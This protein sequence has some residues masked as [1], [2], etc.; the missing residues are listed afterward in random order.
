MFKKI[1]KAILID[2]FLLFILSLTPLLW[3]RG[4]SIMVG[5]DNVFPLNPIEFIKGRF[6]TWSN[7]GL[8]Q[9]Q[10]LIMGTIPIHLIDSLSYIFGFS[11]QTTQKIVY[12]FWFFLMGFS[13]YILASIINRKS[14]VFKLTAVVLYQF[15]FF[16][17]QGWWVGERTKFSAL[18]ALPL[19]LSVLILVYQQKIKP[20]RAVIY[21][22]LIL[23]LF[24]AGGLYGI[25]LF[26]GFF[27]AVGVFIFYF[28]F[29]SLRQR[30]YLI[31]KNLLLTSLITILGFFLINAYFLFPA[32]NSLISKYPKGVSQVGGLSGLIEWSK[33]ISV[34][35]SFLNLFRLQGMAEWYGNPE[36]PYAQTFLNNPYFIALSFLWP[37]L[38][39]SSLIFVRQEKKRVFI[40]YFFLVYLVGIFFTA[41]THPPLGFIYSFL[42]KFI[43]GFAIFRSP[44]YKFAP[45]LFLANA[46]LIAFF[47]DYFKGFFKKFLF[48]SFL[49]IWLGYH[50][51]YFRG[52]FFEWQKDLST[53]LKI[54]N[55]V[56][57]FF[58]WVNY[59]KQD[60]G[61]ILLLPPNSYDWQFDTYRWGYLSSFPIARLGTQ[62]SILV[63]DINLTEI[64][65]R[66][67]QLAYKS[68][69]E[70][71]E[72]FFRKITSHLGVKYLLLRNDVFWDL[73]W[74]KSESPF[75]Y[76]EALQGFNS[77][78]H[79]RS[80][81]EW[82]LYEVD[83]SLPSFYAASQLSY[84]DLPQDE[85]ENYYSFS[86][87]DFFLRQDVSSESRKSLVPLV[88]DFYLKIE[89]LSCRYEKPQHFALPEKTFILPTSPL[90]FLKRLKEERQL[91]ESTP[92]VAVYD[93]LGLSL[94][95]LVELRT[96]V[97]GRKENRLLEEEDFFLYNE[98]LIKID[99][100]FQEIVDFKAKHEAA[101]ALEF[102]LAKEE[103]YLRVFIGELV[104]NE[105]ELKIFEKTFNLF[106]LLR[107]NIEPYL[108]DGKLERNKMYVFTIDKPDNYR[109]LVQ[110]ESLGGALTSQE[111]IKL[112]IDDQDEKVIDLDS[113]SATNEWLDLGTISLSN[114]GHKLTMT[115]PEIESSVSGFENDDV[116]MRT[117]TDHCFASSIQ[118]FDNRKLYK[119]KIDYSGGLSDDFSTYLLSQTKKEVV[120]KALKLGQW[121]SVTDEISYPDE[122]VESRKI[123]FCGPGLSLDN[124][125]EKIN[126]KVFEVVNPLIILTSKSQEFVSQKPFVSFE[127]INPTKYLVEVK[128]VHQPF[129][130]S[131]SEAFDS[132][133]K[134][135]TEFVKN[136]FTVNGYANSWIIDKKGDYSFIVE[137]APQ[138]IFYLGAFITV[139]SLFS[140]LCLVLK[141]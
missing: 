102:Y 123:G 27:I 118:G 49:L 70:K 36:H 121:P 116:K 112:V 93:Y 65:S 89:C 137:Y 43:P 119:I 5:H 128:G 84:L 114:N 135:K 115:V 141:R 134:I 107:E 92:Q 9:D 126:I 117:R 29:I 81:G 2:L 140:G 37:I 25:P 10:S 67:L 110:K 14:S 94:K 62:E 20:F 130:L 1:N 95:R 109:V 85:I 3:F 106:A 78:Q 12:I 74:I 73:D 90:Y 132:Q 98:T 80:F 19:V 50:F 60:D 76:Q 100:L 11:L 91:K 39:F 104:S 101:Y 8:G 105:D 133:W 111:K 7:Q 71:D 61:R 64:E 4:E 99:N 96:L 66:L 56:F 113:F 45:A 83:N 136:H 72:D 53:R 33:E 108:I 24:N 31:V 21:N 88:S 41:G 68:F 26:G 40:L 69:L 58:D 59:E 127:K 32:L 47:I 131:F 30:K 77:V 139:L 48:I 16:V 23:F 54:P 79:I 75:S 82:D 52:N 22:S 28:V 35:S 86:S 17:L 103:D 46:I 34:G 124:L 18:I 122:R 129:I 15:N 138:R 87:G 51:P 63:N 42:M 6:F 44:Y 97:Q 120:R 13:A 57:D 125:E 55:Y 38:V